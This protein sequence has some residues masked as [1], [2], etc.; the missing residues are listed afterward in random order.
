MLVIYSR[1]RGFLDSVLAMIDHGT[2]KSYTGTL[3]LYILLDVYHLQLKPRMPDL[4]VAYSHLSVAPLVGLG[5][6]HRHSSSARCH[7]WIRQAVY[8][9]FNYCSNV[10]PTK[11]QC[12]DQAMPPIQKHVTSIQILNYIP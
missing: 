2:G 4:C 5:R 10:Y 3:P 8:F 1:T 9:I 6:L 7:I 11:V 12:L